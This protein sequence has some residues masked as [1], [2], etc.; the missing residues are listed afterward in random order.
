MTRALPQ[1]ALCAAA[2]GAL[3]SSSR[4]EAV[5]FVRDIQPIISSKCFH[6]HG[7][8]EKTRE[9][10]LRLDLREEAVKERD[11]VRAIV[12]GDPSAS[13][14]ILRITTN[15]KDDVMPPPKEN[16]PLAPREIEL[17]T[18]WVKS[19]AE[20]K[21]HW[22]FVKPQ[23]ATV[24]GNSR[25]A[26]P[27]DAFIR[28]R[29]Q[30]EGL[31]PSPEAD[32]HTLLRRVSL[33]LTG[34]PPTPAELKAFVADSS[35]DAYEKAVDRLLASR[36]YG[37]RWAKMWLDLAR[38]A[39]STGYGSDKFRLNIWPWR[40]W[41]VDA[42]NRNQPYDQFT[43]EQ[44]AG[45]LLPNAT[46]EQIVA[47]AFHRN[48]M[49]NVEGGT[50]DEEYRVAAVKDR[51]ATTGQVWMGL[52]FGCAQCHSHKF[53][54]IS[55]K[56]YY[57]LFAI[58][59]QTEDSDR[60]DEE[61]K[62]PIP[63]AEQEQQKAR[64][65]AEIAAL[66]EKLKA[67]TPEIEAEQHEWEA[68]MAA[69]VP[70]TTLAP[71]E[72]LAASGPDFELQK[73]GSIL[74][75]R[76]EA[77]ESIATLKVRAPGHEVTAFRLEAFQSDGAAA[78]AGGSSKSAPVVTDFRIS[79]APAK[80]EPLRA[81]FIRIELPGKMKMLAL[82]EVQAFSGGENVARRGKAKQSS[83]DFAG[84][85]SRAIDG[86]T[87]GDYY[88]ANS[89]THTR[90]SNDPWWELDFGSDAPLDSIAIWNR[91]DNNLGGRLVGARV[92]LLD[93][94]RQPLWETTVA[95][96]PSP[97][98]RLAV[99]G[100]R[101]IP[102][103]NA[104]AGT[105]EKEFGISAVLDGNPKTGWRPAADSERPGAAVF[106]TKAPVRGD[107]DSVLTFTIKQELDSR[108]RISRFRFSATAK[109]PPIRELPESIKQTLALEPSEREPVQREELSAFF[110]PHSRRFAELNKQ[111][112]AKR[113]E[114]AA[115]KPIAL[116][117]MKER[118]ADKH[119]K[120]FVLNKG[121]FLAPGEEVAAALPGAFHPA[122]ATPEVDRL[123]LAKWLVSRENP[124]T[125][126][127][128][129]NRFWAQLFG[130]GLVESEEDFGTQGALPS[131]PELL[132]WLAVEFMES[133]WD[134]KRLLKVMVTS[135][136]YRQSSRVLPEH[137]Q[138]DARNRLLAHYPRRRLDAE[139]VRDQALM[140]AGLLSRKIGGPSVYPPQPDGLW[141]V[142]FNGGENNYPTSKGEDRYRRG[143]YTFW[144]RTMPNPTMA[145]F[146]AP[147]RETCTIRRVPTNTPLQA[148]VT[149]N[150]P[151][152]VECA[153][154]LAR[155][156]VREGG[157]ETAHRLKFALEL[158]LGRPPAE[159]ELKALAQLLQD[160]LAACA[161][162]TE[163]AK[164]LAT[165]DTQPLGPNAD[166][167]E[168]AAW[169]VVANVLLNLDGVLTKS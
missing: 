17:L 124:L 153:Q 88:K 100:E 131:H 81:R 69:P 67:T 85:A 89:V 14:L 168:I 68:A 42:F 55:H 38:Y 29:L 13:E 70:W 139:G 34:L 143:I 79:I 74:L 32:R 62:L 4:G 24:P 156:I 141:R 33:D 137:L 46:P 167:V 49:T 93:A 144:R 154:A 64:I 104:S 136:T 159:H 115:I 25:G 82:A 135:G 22:S 145:T 20:Y 146:D 7:P 3:L 41:V 10:D 53:D 122:P 132:D 58:F 9:A 142:A 83:T 117:V 72:A 155:R 26:N 138:K 91:T 161:R 110:R 126:R 133:G 37:E 40:D 5:D 96:A 60:E 105:E 90:E 111:I 106:E 50:D 8:D 43:I 80:P 140:L 108:S 109:A 57:Q 75:R 152:F 165:S 119:R 23:R 163:A 16:H 157:D 66:E 71:T 97:S 118:P 107:K 31:A 160:E 134:V 12:P 2:L 121:N 112:D 150:D 78:G 15:D 102:L 19:G 120:T 36:G 94:N 98:S 123:A 158:C 51:V 148:F 11:G 162:D 127:I 166:P 48:T 87:E 61:P 54:P 45:D 86:N 35:A 114:L 116:P 39:D 44:I 27:I 6:C 30:N 169:T 63:T 1:L 77:A 65:N 47:T 128:A 164:K 147:S 92:A 76:G 99:N 113:K 151:V 21:P 84:E 125:A 18:A 59:N 95:S 101:E 130:T 103:H 73:D 56:D 129:V 28:A 52:T 149:L